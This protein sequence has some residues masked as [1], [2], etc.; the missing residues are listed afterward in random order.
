ELGAGPETR[1]RYGWSLATRGR[2]GEA[3]EQLHLAAEQDP[4]S[5]IP[6]FDEFFAY[7]FERNVPGQKQVLQEMLQLHP[8][9]LGA[10]ALTVVM[11][12]EQHDCATAR[13]HADYL[14]KMYPNVPASQATL[15][16]AAACGGEKSEALGRIERMRA[17][18]VPAYQFAI[19][20]ALLHDKDNAIAQL[21]QSAD[22]HEGQILYLKYDPF[23][24]EIRSDPRYVALEKRVGLM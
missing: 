3:H 16:Y 10:H 11:S 12:V 22:A 18:Q 17:L 1:A 13:T 15:A 4:L 21:V 7:N 14:G 8:S 20:Y 19:A 2:F 23:F 6:P 9:F 5:V 24:D